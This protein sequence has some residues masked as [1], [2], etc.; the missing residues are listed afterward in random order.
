MS[1]NHQIEEKPVKGGRAN[2]PII[3]NGKGDTRT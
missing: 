1:D 3:V 2:L